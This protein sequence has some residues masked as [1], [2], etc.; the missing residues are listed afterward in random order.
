MSELFDQNIVAQGLDLLFW[1]IESEL[2]AIFLRLRDQQVIF[3][4]HLLLVVLERF[5]LESE[6]VYFFIFLRTG[7]LSCCIFPFKQVNRLSV[8][9]S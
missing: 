9:L 5:T 4:L 7:F 3:L 1:M 6:S 8:I 2:A